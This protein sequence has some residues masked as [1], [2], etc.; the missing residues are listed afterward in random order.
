MNDP[1]R[2][3]TARPTARSIT[4][5]V[6]APAVLA[7][8]L[9][10]AGC[11][12]AGPVKSV[13]GLGKP[14]AELRT[15]TVEA[16]PR[17]NLGNATQIDVVVVRDATALAELPKTGPDWFRQRDGLRRSLAQRIEVVSLQVP[18]ASP[19]FRVDLPDRT[20]KAAAVQVFANYVAA[21]GWPPISL[22]AYARASLRLQETV[23]T[24]AGN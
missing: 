24:V 1:L 8:V 4:R 18:A 13:F 3:Q 14:H 7:A 15:L 22:T 17:A 9:T 16:D 11:G 20:R 2:H 19:A 6:A 10:L 21:D 5:S 23:I 12:L